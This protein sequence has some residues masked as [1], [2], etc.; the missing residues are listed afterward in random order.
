MV[1][2]HTAWA[3]ISIFVLGVFLGPSTYNMACSTALFLSVGDK[4]ITHI[5]IV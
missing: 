5:Y 1:L 4:T 2:T 3:A